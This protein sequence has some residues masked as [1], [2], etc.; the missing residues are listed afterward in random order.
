MK[1]LSLILLISAICLV[2]RDVRAD[3]GRQISNAERAYILSIA[4]KSKAAIVVCPWAE[5]FEGSEAT[6][7]T[8]IVDCTVVKII[9]GGGVAFGQK[10]KVVRSME[11][12]VST[13]LGELRI[14]LFDDIKDGEIFVD[15][16]QS[17]AYSQDLEKGILGH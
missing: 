5:K 4:Q 14:V 10:L 8:A 11:R 1:Y 13:K 7:Y 9:K 15:A 2:I 16:G 6:L 3:S 12:P 17:P